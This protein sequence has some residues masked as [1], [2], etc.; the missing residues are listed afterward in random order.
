M[1][2]NPRPKSHESARPD[3]RAIQMSR[4]PYLSIRFFRGNVLSLREHGIVQGIHARIR[5]R[6]RKHEAVDEKGQQRAPVSE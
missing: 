3:A 6:D 2:G 5:A 1:L 4:K